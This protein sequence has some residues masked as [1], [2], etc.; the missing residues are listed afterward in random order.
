MSSGSPKINFA[1]IPSNGARIFIVYLG[2][3]LLVACTANSSPVFD[4]FNGDGST[5][6]FTLTQTPVT[7]TVVQ[8]SSVFVDNVYQRLGSGLA[9][10]TLVLTLT[11]T[12]V[13]LLVQTT[14]K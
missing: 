12:S 8:I 5:T 13:H 10:T 4:E 1:D 2:R 3:Q 7:N 14:Y 6:T 9:Y 11:F